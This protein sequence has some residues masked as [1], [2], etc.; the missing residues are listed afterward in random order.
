[1]TLRF[2]AE[3]PG[4]KSLISATETLYAELTEEL[5]AVLQKLKAGEWDAKAATHSIREVR[6]ALKLV[7]EE[8]MKIAEFSKDAAGRGGDGADGALDFDAARAEIG[9]RLACLRDA[10]GG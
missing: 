3:G 6:G 2:T 7:L 1:M 5:L 8:R 9:R 10:G 4:S